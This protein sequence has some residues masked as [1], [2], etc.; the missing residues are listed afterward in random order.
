MTLGLWYYNNRIVNTLNTTIS[1]YSE[2]YLS[3]SSLSIIRI[4]LQLTFKLALKVFQPFY[5]DYQIV[6]NLRTANSVLNFFTTGHF[7]S[8][9]T[10][11]NWAS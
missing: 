8:D 9:S 7:F 10:P 4:K 3:P 5:D 1:L 11:L 2:V 6:G